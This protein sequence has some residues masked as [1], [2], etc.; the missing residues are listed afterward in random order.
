MRVL[1]ALDVTS[2]NTK[3]VNEAVSRPWPP[4]TPFLLLH[5]LDP[6]PFAKAPISLK[7]AKEA[8]AVQLNSASQSLIEAGWKTETDVILGMPR[9]VV[10]QIA[11][12]W[13][14]D[15]VMLGSNEAGALMRLFLGSTA[16][17]VLRHAPCSVEIVRP[18]VQEKEAGKP[19]EMRILVAT[20]GS[21]YSTAAIQS[22]ANRPWPKGST[23]KVISIPEPFM[24]LGEFPY[25]ELKEIE[26]Q[27]TAAL[28]D[29]KR[30][31]ETGAEVLSKAGLTA[32]AETPLP[33]DSDAREI[34]KLA[35]RW[36]AQLVVLGSHGL[37]GFDRLTMGSI[38][39][40]VALHAP[41]SVEVIRA[42]LDLMKNP[43]KL[44]KKGAER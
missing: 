11:E 30:Y 1:I 6:Y 19:R 36:Q 5:V 40:H 13:K 41:C 35:E 20:D 9:R 23:A 10:S 34:V 25:L 28:K 32:A 44:S 31:A 27:N 14:A 21:E 12:S 38:S 39:E 2:Q 3:I 24:P 15:L 26:D 37:R 8:A 22:V 16:R 33:R 18:S 4:G 7:R 17:S 43:K 29:A 42:P